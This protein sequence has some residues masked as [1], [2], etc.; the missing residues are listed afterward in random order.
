MA[1]RQNVLDI[2]GLNKLTEEQSET[3]EQSL[4]KPVKEILPVVEIVE[5][6][7]ILNE[8]LILDKS[9]TKPVISTQ[10]KTVVSKTPEPTAVRPYNFDDIINKSP[11]KKDTQTRVAYDQDN[12]LV[13][14]FNKEAKGKERG[15]KNKFYNL[16][17]RFYKDYYEQLKLEA[18]QEREEQKNNSSQ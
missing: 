15:W 6:P 17:F 16:A 8:T 3:K 12:D 13:V 1:K 14:W 4:D 5:Q 2:F 7:I 10:P 11:L 9:V 18:Q